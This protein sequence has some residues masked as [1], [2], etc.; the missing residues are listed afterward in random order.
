[1]KRTF[2]FGLIGW[3]LEHS[4]SPHIHQAALQALDLEGAYHLFPIAPGEKRLLR[5]M[6]ARLSSAELDGLNV[7]IPYKREIM[8]LLDKLTPA[9]EAIGAVNTIFKREKQLVG[10][11]TDAPGFYTDLCALLDR[12]PGRMVLQAPPQ[13]L[14]LGAGGAARA[15]AYALIQHGWCVTLAARRLNQAQALVS[16]LQ[17]AATKTRSNNTQPCLHAVPLQAQALAPLTGTLNLIVN[18]TPLG[19]G[20]H[21]H[22]SPWPTNA[23]FPP[24]AAL[25]DLVYNPAQTVLMRSARAHGLVAANGRGMLVEQAALAFEIWTGKRAPRHAM[26]A[27]IHPT[28]ESDHD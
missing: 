22:K 16:G 5:E 17:P 13:A 11:N 7:T 9:A 10:E 18:A 6:I 3:P 2:T 1:M 14:I 12:I 21:A 23:P 28:R 8:P 24:Q 25:Y 27:T 15:V 26:L 19:M 20:Q 4:L